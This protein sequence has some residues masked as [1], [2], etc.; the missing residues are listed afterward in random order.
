[1]GLAAMH[2][3]SSALIP[4]SLA[5]AFA[6]IFQSTERVSVGSTGIQGWADSGVA[7]LAADGRWIAF[8]SLAADLTPGDTNGLADV[9]VRDTATGATSIAS[10]AS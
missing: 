8:T 9:F 2:S 3:R 7:A 1:M 10:V 5:F 6:P 4:A